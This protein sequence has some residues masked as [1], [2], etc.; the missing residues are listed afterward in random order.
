MV[1]HYKAAVYTEYGNPV[2]HTHHPTLPTL[3]LHQLKHIQSKV[4][5]KNADPRIS[6]K[7]EKPDEPVAHQRYAQR[8]HIIF[9]SWIRILIRNRVKVWI[10]IRI[11]VKIRNFRG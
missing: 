11:K 6:V 7:S 5:K 2:P 1:S 4:I 10:R 8:V 9:G 3:W